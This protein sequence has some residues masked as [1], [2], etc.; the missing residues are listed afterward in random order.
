[1]L[2]EQ[3]LVAEQK[4]FQSGVSTVA[5]VI[6]AQKDVATAEDG[7]VQSMANYTHAKTFFDQAMG[8]TLAVN[9][10]SMQ[11]AMDGKVRRESVLPPALPTPEHSSDPAKRSGLLR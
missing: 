5:L 2:A 10:V 9:H 11:E 8:R 4:R 7:V 1:V 3:S 6:Q